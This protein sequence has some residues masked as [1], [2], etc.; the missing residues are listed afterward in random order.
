M[1]NLVKKLFLSSI[2]ESFV[3][4]GMMVC[5]AEDRRMG[6]GQW[7]GAVTRLVRRRFF[8][9]LPVVKSETP[10]K[11]WMSDLATSIWVLGSF[12]GHIPSISYFFYPFSS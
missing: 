10:G 11:D 1:T 5:P 2:A 3:G 4:V 12:A 8:Y 6:Q 9:R 7:T